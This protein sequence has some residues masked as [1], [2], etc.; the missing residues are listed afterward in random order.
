MRRLWILLVL[1][2]PVAFSQIGTS[3]ITGRVTDPTGAVSPGVAVTV[4]HTGTNFTF[5]VTTN[6]EGLFRV[7][8]LNP[9]SYRVT[10]E[11]EGFKKLVWEGLDLRTGDTL[12]VDA[13]LQLGSVTELVEVTAPA[14]LLE[15]ET[16]AP[17][18]VVKGSVLYR[19]PFYQRY[20]NSTLNIIPGMT[21]GG[22]AYG[23]DLFS[24]HLAGQRS[25]S[26]GIADDGVPGNDPQGGFRTIKPLQNAVAEVK[27]LTTT[28][29]AEYGHSAG[30]VISVVKKTGANE[31]HGMASM[32]GRSRRMQHRLF[33]ER[34]RTS[35]PTPTA[36]NGVPSFFLQP[37]F[38]IGGPIRL[39]KVYDGRNRTFFFAGYQRLMEKRIVQVSNAAVPTAAM[40]AGDFS[41]GGRG[42]PIFDPFSTARVAGTCP[43]A[44][45]L[46]WQR[47]RMPNDQIPLSR[48][49]PVARRVLDLNPWFAPNVPGTVDLNGPQS[50]YLADE[51]GRSYLDDVSIRLD[52]QFSR[53]FKIYGAWTTNYASGYAAQSNVRLAD[54]D[55]EAGRVQPFRLQNWALGK[56]WMISPT[57]VHDARIGYYRYRQFRLEPDYNED[58]GRQ[59]GIPNLSPLLMPQLGAGD[60]YRP[61]T[62]YGLTGGSQWYQ[63]NE[64]LSFRNDLTKI[65]RTHAFKMGYEWLRFRLNRRDL[66]LPSGQFF[67]N[68]MTAGLQADGLGA[69]VPNTGNTFAGFLFGAVRQATFNIELA[70]WLPRSSMHSFYLQDDWK[71]TP[72]LT[73]NLGVRYSNESP[74]NTKYGQM[75]N[76]SPTGV[77]DVR[78][79][80]VGSIVHPTSA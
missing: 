57:M 79:G 26:I 16:S 23:G 62:L 32:Y 67:F 17:G 53:N 41:F 4:V 37:D 36:P 2:A 1:T 55:G 78:A 66:G 24:Y 30:G 50:N 29:P 64:T 22:Y 42:A 68:G 46:C 60:R 76:F 9:G 31:L 39:P 80:A 38:N 14:T 12:P 28:L 65:H 3:T 33:F 15:T 71:L 19:L 74:F 52:H 73:A 59:L 43:N 18:A 56:T 58:W 63:V 35:A 13:V 34:A 6:T 44:G 51:Y 54:F 75:S 25:G 27:V 69:T 21:S 48:F 45:N 5:T 77:D 61:D 8:S 11:F 70:S 47:T 7:Q 49:D 40:K 72:T 20:I 10:F